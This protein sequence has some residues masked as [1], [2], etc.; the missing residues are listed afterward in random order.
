MKGGIRRNLIESGLCGLDAVDDL[1]PSGSRCLLTLYEGNGN[2]SDARLGIKDALA[3]VLDV[4]G[5]RR[6]TEPTQIL[7][8][9]QGSENAIAVLTTKAEE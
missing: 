5:G 3:H 9:D 7:S 2:L 4:T 1:I 6:V 8:Y